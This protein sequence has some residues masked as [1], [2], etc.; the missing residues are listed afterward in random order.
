[1]KN[2]FIKVICAILILGCMLSASA[3]GVR[4]KIVGDCAV[5]SE[6]FEIDKNMLAMLAYD[7]EY[8]YLYNNNASDEVMQACFDDSVSTKDFQYD[9]SFTWYDKVVEHIKEQVFIL[10]ASC[11]AA[12]DEGIELGQDDI[13]YIEYCVQEMTYYANDYYKMTLPEY[14][15]NI[16]AE[17]VTE[18]TVRSIFKLQRLASLVSDK[19]SKELRGQITDSQIEEYALGMEEKDETPTRNLYY[20]LITSEGYETPT[21]TAQEVYS[22]V[23]NAPEGLDVFKRY[24]EEY[25]DDE[26]FVMS[27]L[28]KG[29]AESTLDEWLYAS[30]RALGDKELLL[31]SIGYC[32]VYYYDDGRPV[33]V[34][35]AIDELTEQSY[36]AWTDEIVDKYDMAFSNR[37]INSIHM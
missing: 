15:E 24:V 32:I 8:A 7:W 31:A 27:D 28:R 34:M 25:S 33:Y 11:E 36:K 20:V 29:D 6:H 2:I 1:M 9:E 35:D 23:K 17:G 18:D 30:D 26:E 21:E 37:A 3:C 12:Y 13:D 4:A 5:A 22:L 19:K 16:Y 14:L 10:L